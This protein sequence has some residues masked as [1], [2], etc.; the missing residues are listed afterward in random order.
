[1]TIIKSPVRRRNRTKKPISKSVTRRQK[2][3]AA[4]KKS[5][6]RKAA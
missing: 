4:R 3:Q 2:V 5:S 6:R 1:M